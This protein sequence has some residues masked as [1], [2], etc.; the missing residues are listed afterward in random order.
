MANKK[1]IISNDNNLQSNFELSSMMSSPFLAAADGARYDAKVTGSEVE[2]IMDVQHSETKCNS[3]SCSLE[4]ILSEIGLDLRDVPSQDD[5]ISWPTFLNSSVAR[6]KT[7]IPIASIERLH[8]ATAPRDPIKFRQMCDS[9][10]STGIY[11]Y[12]TFAKDEMEKAKSSG[13]DLALECRQFPRFSGYPE[14]PATGIAAGALAASLH[15]RQIA[16][17]T[18]D[19]SYGVYQGTAMGKPSKICVEI[20]DC[21]SKEA[22][23]P[24]K[25]FYTGSV[26]FDSLS[27][28][29]LE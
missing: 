22:N 10:G 6:T 1:S 5:G 17:V 26:V 20:G 25:I 2:L 19:G 16:M 3:Q 11:L 24:L 18:T 27:Y 23:H 12:S 28:L 9:I 4:E 14:D 15:K 29:D 8:A 13:G 7:L 21:A